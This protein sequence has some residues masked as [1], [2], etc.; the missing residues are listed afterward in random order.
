M[1]EMI[2]V[3]KAGFKEDPKEMLSSIAFLVTL[4]GMFYVSMWM[5]V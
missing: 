2:K 4:F 3:L 1:L 5:F